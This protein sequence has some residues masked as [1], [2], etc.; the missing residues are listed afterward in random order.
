MEK[1]NDSDTY[2]HHFQKNLEETILGIYTTD[3]NGL[4]HVN[5]INISIF[6]EG[7]IDEEFITV[8]LN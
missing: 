6:E 8:Y 3:I 7:E 5:L 4:C 2:Y 1:Q